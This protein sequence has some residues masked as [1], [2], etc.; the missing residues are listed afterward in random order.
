M[1]R[2]LAANLA[3]ATTI[4]VTFIGIPLIVIFAS[5][6]WSSLPQ[7][8]PRHTTSSTT[9]T[10]PLTCTT[11]IFLGSGGHT[12][13]MLQLVSGLD[14]AHYTP[15]HYVVGWDDSSSIEKVHR[16]ETLLA[17]KKVTTAGQGAGSGSVAGTETE[18]GAGAR[19]R[20]NVVATDALI[21]DTKSSGEFDY[22]VHRI[23]RSRHVHQSMLTTPFTLAKSLFVAMPLIKRLTCLAKSETYPM[24]GAERAQSTGVPGRARRSVLLM[25]GPGTCLAL[26]LAVIG[27]RMAG[28]P[29]DQTPDLV[30]VES[31]A[32]V[33]TLSLAGRL[34][35]PLCDAFLVQWPGLVQRYPRSKYIGILV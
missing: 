19:A 35:Y 18:A 17:A 3:L 15:R 6:L 10:R 33:K 32:R 7:N 13:E 20:P 21:S 28:I 14:C 2:H 11:T 23:P 31:F 8:R 26:A 22:M 9:A 4:T 34:L 24:T 16:L 25:N 27:A 1:D 29:D 5:R 30:F 12:A